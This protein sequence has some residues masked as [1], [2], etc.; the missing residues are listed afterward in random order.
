MIIAREVRI[1]L[2]ILLLLTIILKVY[3]GWITAL[4]ALGM[5]IPIAFVFRDP[6][7]TV[8][9]APLAIVSP[10][11][12]EILAIETLDDPWLNRKAVKISI[13]MSFWDV[14]VLRSPIEGKIRNQWTEK[15][16]ETGIKRRYTYWIQ[17]DEQDD[18]IYSVATGKSAPFIKIN[19]RCGERTGQGQRSGYLYFCGIVDVLVP[20]FSRIRLKVG[21]NVDS[22]STVLA[23]II[24]DNNSPLK[25][26]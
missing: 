3:F 4:I 21:E 5:I 22:G 15:G 10:V 11:N 25:A 20:E 9:S 18:I 24:H 1:Y 17:T 2:L 12:G 26:T 23:E 6:I 19:L 14:H 7:C 8:P 13:K 16:N